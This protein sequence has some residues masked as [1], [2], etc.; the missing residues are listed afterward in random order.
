MLVKFNSSTS[1]DHDALARRPPTP[2][3]PSILHRAWRD[4]PRAVARSHRTPATGSSPMAV[5]VPPKRS[6]PSTSTPARSDDSND[7]QKVDGPPIGL[8]PRAFPLIEL[9]ELTRK[10]DGFVLWEAAKDF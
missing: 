5:R 10:E 8:A 6:L 4:Y 3:N 7:D 9:L 2:R 1:A